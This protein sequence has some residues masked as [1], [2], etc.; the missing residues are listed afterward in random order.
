MN[1]TLLLAVALAS[2]SHLRVVVFELDAAPELAG[3]AK[4][5]TEALLLHLGKKKDLT[6]IAEA[7][8]SILVQHHRDRHEVE[9]DPELLLD[10]EIAKKIS[11]DRL[12]SGR[13]SKFGT[14]LIL[15]LSLADPA[16]GVVERR[17]SANADRPEELARAAQE[18]ADRI[19][20]TAEKIPPIALV[21]A[22]PGTKLA[23]LELAAHDASPEL[24]KNLTDLLALE[25]K[26][27]DSLSVISRD[28]IKQ[29]LEYELA[30][31]VVLC[32][33]NVECLRELG[34]A[35]GVD[36]LVAGAV[37]RLGDT[38]VIHL[39][40]MSIKEAEV[41][42]RVSETFRGSEQMLP[43][44][45]RFAT[46]RLLGRTIEGRGSLALSTPIDDATAALDAG[47]PRAL[48]LKLELDAGKH[49]LYVAAEDHQPRVLDVYVEPDRAEAFTPELVRIPVPWFEEW[50]LWT[51]VG[52]V[53]AGAAG[54]A[55]ILSRHEP[56]TGLVGGSFVGTPPP[57]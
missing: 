50:W 6:A 38:W 54:T 31:Q 46:W 40:L 29:M 48:P 18:C 34:G 14:G 9:L 37:G 35:L 41:V 27:F 33:D 44:A 17:E 55:V 4:T 43:Q 8:V 39:K 42:H 10:A 53:A 51:A 3:L 19:F 13:L 21:N 36:Y 20:G 26:R 15:T 23:V 1:G 5:T 24:A 7:E 25:I 11:A 32:E 22:K 28:E 57:R 49:T 56:E 45:L 12:L 47:P 2:A 30:K 52:V 16:H